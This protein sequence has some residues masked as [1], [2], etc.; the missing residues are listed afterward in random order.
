[1]SYDDTRD[2]R[3]HQALDDEELAEQFRPRI[4]P[5]KLTLTSQLRPP[6]QRKQAPP[7]A[8]GDLV[9]RA[10]DTPGEPL[11]APARERFETSLGADLSAVRVHAGPRS[12]AA[13]KSVGARAYTEGQD[14]HFGEG[15]Y[16]PADPF[17]MHLLAHEVAHTVQQ[18]GSTPTRQDKLEVSSP[19]DAAETEADLAADAMVAGQPA[20][21]SPVASAP[22]SRVADGTAE[23]EEDP[24]SIAAAGLQ[25]GSASTLP[26]LD[27]IQRSFGR[28]DVSGLQ[29]HVGGSAARASAEL[30]AE[31]YAMGEG[32][33]FGT[34]PDL[35]TAAHEAAHVVQQRGGVDVPG[36]MGEAGDTHEQHA[37]AV[38]DRVVAGAS[39]EDLLDEYAAK[40]S[41]T[42]AQRRAVARKERAE[43]PESEG[44]QQEASEDG[45][46]NEA[47]AETQEVDAT[48]PAAEQATAARA[49][50]GGAAAGDDKQP[51]LPKQPTE[52]APESLVE[53][54]GGPAAG[55]AAAAEGPAGDQGERAPEEMTR[56]VWDAIPALQ[57]EIAGAELAPNGPAPQAAQPQFLQQAAQHLFAGK[58]EPD[59]M[60]PLA[61]TPAGAGTVQRKAKPGVV[62]RKKPT[63]NVKLPPVKVAL[64]LGSVPSKPVKKPL[65]QFLYWGYQG[66]ASGNVEVEPPADRKAK[67]AIEIEA[68]PSRKGGIIEQM[69]ATAPKGEIELWSKSEAEGAPVDM[70]LKGALQL[71]KEKVNAGLVFT[72]KLVGDNVELDAGFDLVNWE[73]E[74]GAKFG[75]F[76]AALNA[77]SK[78]LLLEHTTKDGWKFSGYVKGSASVDAWLNEVAVARWIVGQLAKMAPAIP[79][80]GA[81]A[82]PVA[83]GA[84][85]V[86]MWAGAN[87]AGKSIAA[88]LDHAV[89]FRRNWATSYYNV[90]LGLKPIGG[91]GGAEGGAA[92]KA[93]RGSMEAIGTPIAAVDEAISSHG[94]PN[95]TQLERVAWD[96]AKAQALAMYEA[97]HPK[98]MWLWR[99]GWSSLTPRGYETLRHALGVVAPK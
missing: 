53:S 3:P 65:G 86:M 34:Q 72:S 62:Q 2:R 95:I 54:A 90:A 33:A 42:A 22:L 82:A 24:R 38:A 50:A 75:R 9:T 40:R 31:A 43:T 69:N 66:S 64:N 56:E 4:A 74:S 13:A 77:S 52:Q 26:H 47:T 49:S 55:P 71:G 79:A 39:A 58:P 89:Q 11:P 23:M 81:I 32:V 6:V 51:K 45:V 85:C 76:H 21:V 80:A 46:S 61:N 19:Q 73:K 60:A 20:S 98:E 44:T 37:D 35:H 14:I 94:K 5:G 68:D 57:G 27:R 16:A 8:A 17:G 48:A 36:G 92:A 25:A 84:Y 1:M 28:H 30:G 15:Q 78:G 18:A 41:D 91:T 59:A 88:S 10:A 7:A 70:E 93:A 63:G 29:A 83:I 12:A 96:A 67:W 87:A 99:R 97:A